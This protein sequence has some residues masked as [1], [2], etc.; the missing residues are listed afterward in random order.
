LYRSGNKRIEIL[1]LLSRRFPPVVFFSFFRGEIDNEK[2]H[3]KVRKAVFSEPLENT[4]KDK[5]LVFKTKYEKGVP[6][7]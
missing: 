7:L 5:Y 1:T 2:N 3:D 4:A 6:H